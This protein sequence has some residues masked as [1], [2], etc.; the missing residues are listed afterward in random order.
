MFVIC[1]FFYA[2]LLS[3]RI[4]PII[5]Y[6]FPNRAFQVIWCV[7]FFS[8]SYRNIYRRNTKYRNVS[9]FQYRAALL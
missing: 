4:T 7:C 8:L 5:D 1:L 6:F 3:Y 2:D 9:F